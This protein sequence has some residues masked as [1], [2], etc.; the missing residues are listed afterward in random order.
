MKSLLTTTLALLLLFASGVAFAADAPADGEQRSV[1][2]L[3][4]GAAQGETVDLAEWSGATVLPTSRTEFE[5]RSHFAQQDD[6]A[7]GGATADATG[8]DKLNPGR[9]LILSA[10]VP[11]AGELYAGSKLKAAFFFAVEVA[12]WYGAINYALKGDDKEV[13]YEN[14]AN[15]HWQEAYYRAVEFAAAQDPNFPDGS[16]GYSGTTTDWASLEW[17][18]KINWL[19]QNFTHELPTDKNQQYYENIGKYLTQFGYGWSD[20]I[21]SRSDQDIVAVAQ[22]DGYNW[23]DGGGTSPFAYHYIDLRA[24]S[25][26]LLD[27]SANLFSVIMVNHVI[28]ALDAG[29]TVRAHQKKL[30]RV[31]PTTSQIIHN[32]HPVMTAG[33][34][35]RF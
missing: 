10:I 23:I 28:S 15:E 12:A 26:D 22:S 35:I 30:A 7:E 2:F 6:G 9:A 20:W 24:E 14:Y 13:E 5:L 18:E 32:Q 1:L 3:E 21:G 29:F 11:G 17:Q 27:A 33:L 19:P 8:A 31:E 25:N 4:D 34:R 16:E